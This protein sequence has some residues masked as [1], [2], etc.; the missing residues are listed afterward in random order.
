MDR[1]NAKWIKCYRINDTWELS[2][3]SKDKKAIRS[4]WVYKNKY[5]PIGSIERYKARLVAKGFTQI[6]V[7]DYYE[8]FSPMAKLGTIWVV[9]AIAIGFQ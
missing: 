2:Y 4:K 6:E 5:K 7:E 9:L 1:Y 8:A 3:F